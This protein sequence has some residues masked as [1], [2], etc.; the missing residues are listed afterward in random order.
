MKKLISG[1]SIT[2][3]LA[4]GVWGPVAAAQIT[5]P[6]SHYLVD[7]KSI[8]PWNAAI[9]Q[10]KDAIKLIDGGASSAKDSLVITPATKETD[11]DALNLKWD[12]KGIK[13]QWGVD[14]NV[15]RLRLNNWNGFD[16]S[17]VK[18]KATLIIN[19]KVITPP[20]RADIA[21]G[22]ECANSGQ[23][24]P[25]ISLRK[26]MR[27]TKKNKWVSISLPLKCFAKKSKEEFDFTQVTS[28]FSIYSMGKMEIELGDV[29]LAA[30]PADDKT[31][32]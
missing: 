29:H 1:F 26:T 20:K 22:I 8:K 5:S 6:S 17:S 18:D 7:G 15:L 25:E 16:L 10:G 30:L 11:G 12:P 2:I 28:M 19:Y 27:K 21:V 3:C 13:N 4:I 14:K 23:C 32:C 31:K 9:G 24:R